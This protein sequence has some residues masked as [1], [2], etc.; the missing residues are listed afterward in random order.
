MMLDERDANNTRSD[1]EIEELVGRVG[2]L[3]VRQ[4]LS[5]PTQLRAT[6]KHWLGI[7]HD[8]IVDVVRK[9][10]AEHRRLYTSGSGD[11]HFWMIEAEIRKA[12]QEKHPPRERADDEP[13]RARRRRA[14]GIRKVHNASGFPDLLVE[15]PAA[16]LLREPESSAERPSGLVSY[17]DTGEAINLEDDDSGEGA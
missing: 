15:G 3:Y 1:L 17:E 10:F 4:G 14:G 9:H 2:N 6:A 12:W 11:G 7:S 16:R 13:E 5:S 8:E